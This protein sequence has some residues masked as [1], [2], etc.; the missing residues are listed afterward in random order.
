MFLDD[1]GGGFFTTGIDAESLVVRP[2]D[3]VDNAVPS[4]NSVLALE[5]QRLALITGD[6]SY[7]TP[8][9]G[10]LRLVRQVMVRSPQGFGHALQA[11]DFYT[12]SPVEIVVVGQAG[13]ADRD[14]LLEVIRD[15]FNPNKVLIAS[16]EP[17]EGDVTL[18]PLLQDRHAIEGKATVYVCRNGTCKLPVTELDDVREQ[19]A[20]L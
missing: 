8:A 2:K 16:D 1:D 14:A 5:L 18:I 11:A 4:A 3:L 19:L 12:S 7:E 6:E 20:A 17:D 15:D 10:A 13:S 9:V